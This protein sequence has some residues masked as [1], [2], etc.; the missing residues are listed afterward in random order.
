MPIEENTMSTISQTPNVKNTRLFDNRIQFVLL[1][2]AVIAMLAVMF[3][4]VLV[5]QGAASL[6]SNAYRLYRQGEWVS[7][8]FTPV[9]AYQI[10][11]RDEVTSPA[12]SVEAYQIFRQG[13]WASVAIDLTSYH[14][15]ERTL[16]NAQAGMAAYHLG[17]RT[18]IDSQTG[19]A[20]YLNSERTRVPIPFTL[21]QQSEWFGQ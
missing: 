8:P 10:F 11:R 16:L 12:S 4:N 6:S 18:L 5:S 19:L 20:I 14:L 21:Y 17:E 13:E 3:N 1:A 2:A 7:V 15:S 9:Q